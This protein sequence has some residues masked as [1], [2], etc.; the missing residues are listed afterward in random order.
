V[1]NQLSRIIL[2][3]CAVILAV[4]SLWPTYQDYKY[5]KSLSVL[6]GKDSL[7]YF[8]LHEQDFQKAKENRMKLGLDLQGGMRVVLEVDVLQ[9]I[10][11]L[12]KNR[13]R[14]RSGRSRSS[15]RRR[16]ATRAR[17]LQLSR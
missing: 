6:T 11:D 2:I 15:R 17:A 1:R 5:R 12:G 7:D 9:L 4:Y 3:L 8:E 16:A 13:D 14:A 10:D